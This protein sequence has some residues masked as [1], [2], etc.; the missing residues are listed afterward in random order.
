MSEPEPNYKFDTKPVM[1]D[2]DCESTYEYSLDSIS[3][4]DLET[5]QVHTVESM[6]AKKVPED[7]RSW[8]NSRW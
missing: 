6:F 5:H 2:G 7:D 3:W 1:L 8:N 4:C